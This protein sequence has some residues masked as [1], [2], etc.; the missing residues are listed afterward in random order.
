MS[1]KYEFPKH[2]F[3]HSYQ[4]DVKNKEDGMPNQRNSLI[5]MGDSENGKKF[6]NSVKNEGSPPRKTRALINPQKLQQW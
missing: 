4:E 5:L 6:G 3:K 2:K 1:F